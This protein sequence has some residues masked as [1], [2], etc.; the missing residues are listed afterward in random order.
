MGTGGFVPGT[1]HIISPHYDDAALSLA[2]AIRHWCEVG[3]KVTLVNCF[4]QSDHAPHARITSTPQALAGRV[5]ARLRRSLPAF[6]ARAPT[7]A[8]TITTGRRIEIISALRQQEDSAFR[9][10]YNPPIGALELG[11]QDAPLRE[12]PTARAI[13][14][15][16]LSPADIEIAA[17]LSGLLRCVMVDGLVLAPLGLGGHA[18]HRIARLAAMQSIVRARLAFYEDLP[19]ATALAETS[20]FEVV[21][22]LQGAATAA[23][24]TERLSRTRGKSGGRREKMRLISAYR[25]QFTHQELLAV[26]RLGGDAER[27]WATDEWLSIYGKLGMAAAS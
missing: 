8:P 21:A 16:R 14:G 22:E 24:G 9:N 17:R 15:G 2:L 5:L 11:L 23:A 20:V 12:D 3:V 13:L 26:G 18:D 4:T 25:S 6:P 1:V 19:Y 10:R 27:I 7:G